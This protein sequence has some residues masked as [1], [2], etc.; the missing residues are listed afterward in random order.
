[1]ENAPALRVKE[2]APKKEYVR[3]SY[4]GPMKTRTE[5]SIPLKTPSGATV[6]VYPVVAQKYMDQGAVAVGDSLEVRV[7]PKKVQEG[8]KFLRSVR[9]QAFKVVDIQDCDNFVVS[10]KIVQIRFLPREVCIELSSCEGSKCPC[11]EKKK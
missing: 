8:D 7:C 5:V 9:G 1:M 10:G 4:S 11:K 2:K 3:T 6:S